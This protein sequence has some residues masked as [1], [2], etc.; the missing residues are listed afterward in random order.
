ML[1][2]HKQ[3]KNVF[4]DLRNFHRGILYAACDM[5]KSNIRGWHG[6]LSKNFNPR[7]NFLVKLIQT[8]DMLPAEAIQLEVTVWHKL[9][10][11]LLLGS[12]KGK[13]NKPPNLYRHD[14]K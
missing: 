14:P 11:I 1:D 12:I 5:L 4:I 9:C 8:S 10:F 6:R 3:K 2:A 13:T 7:D